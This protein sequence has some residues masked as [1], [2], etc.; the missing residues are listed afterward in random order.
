MPRSSRA[1]RA[2]VHAPSLIKTRAQAAARTSP[3][4]RWSAAVG[5]PRRRRPSSAYARSGLP[6]LLPQAGAEW[7]C[8]G[9][10]NELI[11]HRME[12]PVAAGFRVR[13]NVAAVPASAILTMRWHGKV[14]VFLDR[15]SILAGGEA[16]NQE[17]TIDLAPLLSPG[18]AYVW[19][20]DD[21]SPVALRAAGIVPSVESAQAKQWVCSVDGLNWEPPRWPGIRGR[22]SLHGRSPHPGNR[23]R[24]TGSQWSARSRRRSV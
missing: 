4:I 8:V 11:A 20:S 23:C 22:R 1:S 18:K 13:L 7:I 3:W 6:L 10:P 15:T 19:H 17:R 16:W 12:P 14:T 24:R 5:D 9:R 2:R 21:Q